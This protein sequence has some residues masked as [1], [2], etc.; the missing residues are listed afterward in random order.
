MKKL[1]IVIPCYNEVDD[2]PKLLERFAR[3][4]DD[5]DIEVIIIDNGSVDG[6]SQLLNK[7]LPQYS[8]AKTLRIEKNQ[9]YGF[10][11]LAGLK[12]ATGDF[13]GWA[14]IDLQTDP[15]DVINAYRL[16][17]VHNFA[18]DLFVKGRRKGRSIF[19]E[20]FTFGMSSFESL[21]L[22]TPLWD[23]NGQPTIFHRSFFDSWHNPPHD[24]SLNLYSYFMA[25]EKSLNVVRFNIIFAKSFYK[26]TFRQRFVAKWRG[27][28]RTLIFSK[29]LKK[30][31]FTPPSSV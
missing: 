15:F 6:T 10:G 12:M 29:Q 11:I 9:G 19:D 21:Y 26:Q 1:S 16:L 27:T 31:L 7:L 20:F 2:I 3:V 24:F 17:Q 5:Y 22:S 28:K 23:I 4:I 13:L 14:H 25:R 8:F 30:G 18:T